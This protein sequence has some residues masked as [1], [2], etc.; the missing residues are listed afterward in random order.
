[1]PKKYLA[2]SA[3]LFGMGISDGLDMTGEVHG[4]L[5]GWWRTVKGDW[6][7]LVN[8]AIPYADGRRHT[9]QLTDQ[10]VPGYALRKRDNT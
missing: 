7:G 10:L 1:M 3:D 8:Y 6:L 5:T 4:H 9:L 2:S